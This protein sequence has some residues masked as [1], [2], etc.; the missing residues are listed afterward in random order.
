LEDALVVISGIYS[1]LGI[2]LPKSTVRE[3]SQHLDAHPQGDR[4]GHTYS[5]DDLGLNVDR[6]MGRFARYA[7]RF[8]S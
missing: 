8:L 3:M 6:E 1:Q 4:G 7:D 5:F 2:E